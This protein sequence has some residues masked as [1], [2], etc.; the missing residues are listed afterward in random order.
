M[1]A[2]DARARTRV[3]VTEFDS[4]GMV[5]GGTIT[6]DLIDDWAIICDG[7]RYVDG[8]QV[9]GNGTVQLTLKLKDPGE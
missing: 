7:R 9:Y 5:T 2:V 3:E 8:V 1:I 4:E 6:R